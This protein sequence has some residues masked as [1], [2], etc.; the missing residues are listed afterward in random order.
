MK[1]WAVY[2]MLAVLAWGLWAFLPKFA[3][4]WLDPKSA[5]IYEVM[6]GLLTG[7]AVFFVLRPEMGA[8]I[9]GIVPSV[10]TGVAGYLGLLFFMYALRTGKLSVIAPLTALYPVVTIALAFIFFREK[11]NPAQM[12]G[13]ALAVLS[14]VLIS[15]E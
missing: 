1:D 4:T 13:V 9:R 8:D 6:G 7:L 2:S 14:V 15:Y 12:A 5:F 3:V 11:L 10:L